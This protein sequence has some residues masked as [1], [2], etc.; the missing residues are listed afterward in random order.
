MKSWLTLCGEA[1]EE[2]VESMIVNIHPKI[3]LRTKYIRLSSLS[4]NKGAV[5]RSLFFPK[6]LL[7][8]SC[9]GCLKLALH[10]NILSLLFYFSFHSLSHSLRLVL[11]SRLYE[12]ENVHNRENNDM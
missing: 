2:A 5:L 3:L 4:Y 7:F 8:N 10:I 11:D 12:G 6:Q 1:N 9:Q